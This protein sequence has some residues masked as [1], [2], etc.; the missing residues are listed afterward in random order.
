MNAFSESYRGKRVL[1]TGHTGFKGSW[2]CEWLLLLGAEVKG[3]G[4]DPNSQPSLFECLDLSSRI[5]DVRVDI[6]E[7]EA[8]RKEILDWGPDLIFHMAAQPLVRYSYEYPLETVTTNIMGTTYLLEALR[9]MDSKCSVVIVTTD[10]CYLNKEWDHGYRE[11]DALGGYDLYSASKA[12]VEVLTNA[13]RSSFFSGEGNRIQLATAR[14]GNVIGGGDWAVDRIVPDAIRNLKAGNPIPVRNRNATRP[15]QHVIEPIG[16]YLKLGYLLC[17]S[18]ESL[19][20]GVP[21]SDLA[22]AFNF[23]PSIRSNRTVWELVNS[24]LSHWSGECWD[25]SDP[26]APHEAQKLNLAT[27]KAY[28]RLG[29]APVWDFARTVEETIR[30]Y[31]HWNANQESCEAIRTFTQEQIKKYVTAAESQGTLGIH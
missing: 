31:A 20:D 16:G 14:A 24:I 2:M 5:N 19:V 25:V 27:D 8:L 6:C 28:H 11:E 13:Y 12:C 3:I 1:V 4:L 18:N 15:W 9:E 29:W 10:K 21:A 7:K 22:T 30:W 23:G 17:E 26:N